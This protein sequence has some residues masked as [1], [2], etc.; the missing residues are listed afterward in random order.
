V[1]FARHDQRKF[2]VEM[3]AAAALTDVLS[4]ADV[5]GQNA[6]NYGIVG[7]PGNPGEYRLQF[8]DHQPN[9]GNGLFSTLEEGERLAYSPRE[10]LP[11]KFGERSLTPLTELAFQSR[12]GEFVKRAIQDEVHGKLFVQQEGEHDTL[13]NSIRRAKDDVARLVASAPVNFA[14]DAMPILESYIAKI[15]DNIVTY[16]RSVGKA[17]PEERGRE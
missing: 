14:D 10:S 8:V 12:S 3:S 6:K 16:K 11:K 7:D 4:V 17:T 2:A 15:Q 5:F 1:Q 13:E 9:P